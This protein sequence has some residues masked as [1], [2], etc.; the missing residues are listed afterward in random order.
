MVLYY[1]NLKLISF[2]KYA[3]QIRDAFIAHKK[4]SV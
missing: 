1:Y 3:K 4:L 2:D